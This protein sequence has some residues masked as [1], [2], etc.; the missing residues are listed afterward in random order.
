MTI[1]LKIKSMHLAAE[2]GI[3]RGRERQLK[4]QLTRLYLLNSDRDAEKQKLQN[5][6][7]RLKSK[8][9]SS[10]DGEGVL[11]SRIDILK[12]RLNHIDSLPN[13]EDYRDE[14]DARINKISSQLASINTHRRDKSGLRGEARSTHLAYGFS[15]GTAYSSIES[16]P[17]TNPNWER[18]EQM[19]KKYA[20]NYAQEFK[21]WR[22]T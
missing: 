17:K 5:S 3:I 20:P 15:K 6:I 1:E 7:D 13:S 18:V 2:S 12:E 4:K 16:N 10:G 11:S 22:E 14:I 21:N 9:S 8:V 19:A